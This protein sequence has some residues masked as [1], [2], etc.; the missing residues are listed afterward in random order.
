MYL[1]ANGLTTDMI[2]R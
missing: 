1:F 2:A